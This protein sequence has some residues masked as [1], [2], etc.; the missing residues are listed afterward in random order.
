MVPVNGDG[1]ESF[2]ND[3]ENLCYRHS[4]NPLS[5]DFATTTT[6]RQ[7]RDMVP[8]WIM[9]FVPDGFPPKKN[10]NSA[11]SLPWETVYT[12]FASDNSSSK[13]WKVLSKPSIWRPWDAAWRDKFG[14][15]EN[16]NLE[17]LLRGLFW[18]YKKN[19][20]MQMSSAAVVMRKTMPAS[21]LYWGTTCFALGS[22]IVAAPFPVIMS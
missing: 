21:C 11:M 5:I 1:Y 15:L 16:L 2:D 19:L 17:H 18:N 8:C 3:D 20:T 9:A 12:T 13:T 7:T 22:W 6:Q 10:S 14:F 4:P